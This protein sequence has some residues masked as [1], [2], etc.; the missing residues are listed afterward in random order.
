M[1]K[2]LVLLFFFLA[3][4]P[5]QAE[6]LQWN[7][8]PVHTNFYFDIR[9]TFAAVRGQFGDFAGKVFFD[10]DRPEESSFAFVIQAASVD[11]R[12]GKRDIHLRSPD[13]FDAARY[14]LITFTSTRVSAAGPDRYSVE[15]TL[16]IKD[17]TRKV[18][19][20]FDYHGQ[21]E[22]PLKKGEVVAGLDAVLTIDRLQYHVGDGR[23]YKMGVVGRDVDIL[24]TLELLGQSP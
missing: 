19:L 10:P 1:K 8:D 5:C 17:V 2:A 16:S 21:R 12:V 7:L 13:F 15:G 23:F 24:V 11:T 22:N 3:A 9:H 18:A 14:P 20:A 6:G 4:V